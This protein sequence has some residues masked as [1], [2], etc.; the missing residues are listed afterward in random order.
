MDTTSDKS[1][2]KMPFKLFCRVCEDIYNAKNDKKISILDKFISKYRGS[3]EKN[4]N[5]CIVSHLI[6]DKIFYIM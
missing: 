1:C 3:T 5:L 6:L 2:N 4:D